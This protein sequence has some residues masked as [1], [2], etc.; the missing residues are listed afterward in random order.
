MVFDF[1][2]VVPVGALC[3]SFC[4]VRMFSSDVYNPLI[5]VMCT[6]VFSS[7]ASVIGLFLVVLCP[8]LVLFLC[9]KFRLCTALRAFRFSL[10]LRP[11]VVIY[12]Y[13]HNAS[14][15]APFNAVVRYAVV[16]D[17]KSNCAGLMWVSY[18]M[19]DDIVAYS[20]F[21]SSDFPLMFSKNDMRTSAAHSLIYSSWRISDK[22]FSV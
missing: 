7:W 14:D 3:R 16:R 9:F 17:V 10:R 18:C 5:L 6:V 13:V 11:G 8:L 21:V 15:P 1:S 2:H 22:S 12:Q 4:V 20:D 19:C